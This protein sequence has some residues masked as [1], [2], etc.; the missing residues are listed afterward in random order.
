MNRLYENITISNVN[1]G[2]GYQKRFKLLSGKG[3]GIIDD[4]GG[5]YYLEDI[6]NGT[7]E[8]WEKR[9][10]N[11]FDIEKIQKDIDIEI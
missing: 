9:D 4:C 1:E 5:P 2:Y 10:I 11:E 7:S 8:D 3:Y 6:F